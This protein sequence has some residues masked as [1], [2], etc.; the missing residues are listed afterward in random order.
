MK[1]ESIC[2]TITALDKMLPAVRQ[3]RAF[4]AL[5]MKTVTHQQ[6]PLLLAD[7]TYF[8]CKQNGRESGHSSRSNGTIDQGSQRLQYLLRRGFKMAHFTSAAE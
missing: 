3:C 1:H 7:S 4:G 2:D 8:G 5:V 6:Q